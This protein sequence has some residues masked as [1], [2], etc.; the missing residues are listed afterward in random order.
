MTVTPEYKL[1]S[2]GVSLEL[3]NDLKFLRRQY[4]LSLETPVPITK[5]LSCNLTFTDDWT[6]FMLG[7]DVT[8]SCQ[9]AEGFPSLAISS[10]LKVA[11]TP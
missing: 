2:C 1:L 11:Y 9:R 10:N 3:N 4:C 7:S 5:F 6:M 8:G